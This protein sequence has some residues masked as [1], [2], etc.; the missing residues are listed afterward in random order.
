MLADFPSGDT[1]DNDKDKLKKLAS[2]AQ[3]NANYEDTPFVVTWSSNNNEY[4]LITAADYT[5]FTFMRY[6]CIEAI[7]YPRGYIYPYV[8]EDLEQD[9]AT[10]SEYRQ[11]LAKFT[12]Q[13]DNNSIEIDTSIGFH[14]QE[15]TNEEDALA[16]RYN[17]AKSDELRAII[18]T[19]NPGEWILFDGHKDEFERLV[20]DE[21]LDI[22]HENQSHIISGIYTGRIDNNFIE[23]EIASYPIV[24]MIHVETEEEIH[25]E[26]EA[27]SEL[28]IQYKISENGQRIIED[29]IVK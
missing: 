26:I 4:Y 21:V 17:E 6:G 10:T 2:Q 12:G 27:S 13:I 7:R 9:I 1:N 28:V 8:V 3:K 16:V 22:G 20:L 5:E 24:F 25:G 15:L 29:F 18:D 11:I 14:L 23:V 19:V